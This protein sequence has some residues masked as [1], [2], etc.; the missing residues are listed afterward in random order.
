MRSR[1]ARGR[2]NGRDEG[3]GG[4]REQTTVPCAIGLSVATVEC[5][6]RAG[7]AT[8]GETIGAD[9]AMVRCAIGVGVGI[10]PNICGRRE[11]ESRPSAGVPSIV[12]AVWTGVHIRI[13][14]HER[15]AALMRSEEA[16][17]KEHKLKDLAVLYQ[18]S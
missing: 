5:A 11:G 1:A 10:G 13:S 4:R 7:V 2:R 18:C 15:G 17:E 6:L 9:I 8:T 12:K 16:I 14:L 3:V